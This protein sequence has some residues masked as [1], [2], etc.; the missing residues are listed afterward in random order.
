MV[1]YIK[2]GNIFGRIGTGIGKGLAEQLPK[3]IENSRHRAGLQELADQSGN[4][5]PAQFLA[6]AA[7]TYGITPQEIQS[8]GELA[9]IQNKG[10][11]FERIARQGY[12][13]LNAQ[14]SPTGSADLRRVQEAN[15]LQRASQSSLPNQQQLQSP[16]NQ[17]PLE[18]D[19]QNQQR[20]PV[21]AR[22]ED[23]P[24]VVEGNPLS[25]SNLTR[26]PWTSQ[27]RNQ[28]IR[29][30]ISEGF[31]P[32]Q[33]QQLASDDE[34]RD[35]SQ[36]GANK[37]RQDEIDIGKSK[38]R[39]TLKRHLETKLQKTGENLYK[40]V[41]GPMILNAER[42]MTRDL[43]MNPKAD[44][45]NIANDWSERLYRT[46]IAKGRLNTLGKTTGIE[47]LI[48]GQ[49]LSKSLKEYQEIFKRS[50]N[51]E[52]FNKILTGPDFGLSQRGAAS[53]A[54]PPS[55]KIE[56]TINDFKFTPRK[57]HIKGGTRPI[58]YE[59]RS[60]DAKRAALDIEKDIG[61]DDS[62]LAISNKLKE[63]NP[64]F[65][66][67]SFFDQLSEDKDQIGLN[68]RQRLELTERVKDV[69]PW[70]WGDLLF[71]PFFKRSK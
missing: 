13:G 3:E 57:T 14:F 70:T 63:K 68:D 25:P 48:K 30:Y 39:D 38:V 20:S 6:K 26:N 32:D 55:K 37:A 59:E 27:E 50:G 19:T 7:G 29:D 33:A 44:I 53:Q 21:P 18:Q 10:N 60:N 49:E 36:P 9:K 67:A 17:P 4:L 43:I 42:G 45:D 47:A 22:N 62:I 35:L 15:I 24:Q 40:D 54:F 28:A 31:T 69:I 51:L 12:P 5:S 2:Q 11:A 46:A 8:F 64:D 71:L 65:D 52:E 16:S 23:I 34:N 41:E 58:S 56:A 1:Q 66:E 61:P